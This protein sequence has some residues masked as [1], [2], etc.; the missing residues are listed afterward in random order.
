MR[1]ALGALAPANDSLG[2]CV[3]LSLSRLCAHVWLCFKH[4]H[5]KS[6]MSKLTDAV[7]TSMSTKSKA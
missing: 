4:S 5:D 2:V 3:C 1:G 7:F 6:F